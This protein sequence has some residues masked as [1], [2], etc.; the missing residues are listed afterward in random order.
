MYCVNCGKEIEEDAKFCPH[1]GAQVQEDKLNVEPEIKNEEVAVTATQAVSDQ[2]CV[3]P[4]TEEK[5]QNKGVDKTDIKEGFLKIE[6]LMT[7][8]ICFATMFILL[9]CSFFIGVFVEESG[10]KQN[11]FH[12]FGENFRQVNE[13][14]SL[15]GNEFDA[16]KNMLNFINVIACIVLSLNLIVQ[17]TLAA[18]GGY[19]GAKAM[20]NGEKTPVIKYA[21][22]MFISFAITATVIYTF[23]Y[24]YARTEILGINV[25]VGSEMSGGSK[26]GLIIGAIFLFVVYLMQKVQEGKAVLDKNY[27]IKLGLT[28]VTLIFA[29][30][31][32]STLGKCVYKMAYSVSEGGLST[33]ITMKYSAASYLNYMISQTL[34]T[35]GVEYG[36]EFTSVIFNAL[37]IAGAAVLFVRL[38]KIFM[39]SGII[40]KRD[41][42]TSIVVVG[43]SLINLILACVVAS[44]AGAGME[45]VSISAGGTVV[46]FVFSLLTLGGIFAYRF[47]SQK[48]AD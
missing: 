2:V 7:P 16:Q 10:V 47:L 27:L 48:I 43:L 3:A 34:G 42:I 12:Y 23:E 17:V 5:P 9:L 36:L 37:A 14:F 32:F 1:C 35:K 15:Y 28:V 22:W 46:P 40:G 6:K 20:K 11:T 29:V 26:A 4:V 39:T 33:S 45:R 18:L 30:I 38:Y 19:K 44:D 13:A 25:D 8:V 21:L 41:F 31:T 24:A